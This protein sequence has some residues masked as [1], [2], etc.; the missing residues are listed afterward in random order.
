M[1]E[2][3]EPLV[4]EVVPGA[5]AAH[6][7]LQ[8][9]AGWRYVR[10]RIDLG[11]VRAL[12]SHSSLKATC[13]LHLGLQQVPEHQEQLRAHVLLL[14]CVACVLPRGEFGGSAQGA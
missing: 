12:P 11:N 1:E 5:F 6:L 8:P 4:A 10:G 7:G 3:E 13:K 2:E 14:D 9:A